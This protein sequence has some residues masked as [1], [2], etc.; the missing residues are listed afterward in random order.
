MKALK[1][2]L[3][4]FRARGPPNT[5]QQ[6]TV[7]EANPQDARANIPPA[8]AEVALPTLTPLRYNPLHDLESL[9]WVG[10]YF[11][12]KREIFPFASDGASLVGEDPIVWDREEQR[13]CA[14]EVFYSTDARSA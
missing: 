5:Q 7:A 11:L 10:V 14:D 12:L 8:H 9:W 1:E 3:R 2:R 13:T 6:Q 4:D